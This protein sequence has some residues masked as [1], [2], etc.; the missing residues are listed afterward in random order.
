MERITPDAE[1]F[2]NLARVG[3]VVPVFREILADLDT[4][5]GAFLKIDDGRWSF[6]LESVEGGETWGRYSFLG[7]APRWVFRSSGR[8]VS[9]EKP[10]IG[11]QETTVEDPL[12]S[13][14]ELITSHRAVSVPGLPRFFGGAVGYL[15]YAMARFWER[16]PAP[17]PDGM[18]MPECTFLGGSD[19][20]I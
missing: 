20:V 6:L 10:A 19:L 4:P 1:L 16:L 8:R 12:A 17:K 3:H 14:K 18:G 2:M 11:I 13:L 7:S 15:G 5:V 9:V